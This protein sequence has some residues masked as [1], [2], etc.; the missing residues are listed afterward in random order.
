MNELFEREVSISAPIDVVFDYHRRPQALERLTPPWENLR[1][2]ERRGGIEDQG[3]VRLKLG[4]FLHWVARGLARPPKV[5]VCASGVGF[6]GDRGA[7]WLDEGSSGG[8]GLLAD[9]CRGWEAAAALSGVR[10]VCAR[11]GMVLSRRDGALSLIAA[12]FEWG[13]GGPLGTGRQYL[14]W[15]GIDDAVGALHRAL[16]DPTLA[17]AVNV[18]AP[19]PVENR[20]FAATLGRVLR[21]PSLVRIPAFAL[22]LLLGRQKADELALG[23]QRVRPGVL[24]A[25]GFRYL[26]PDLEPTLRH[27]YG[28]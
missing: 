5:F 22:R 7:E 28:R 26:T 6:Y 18:V 20:E 27:L 10:T 15:I 8:K 14:S 25:V 19:H 17:G 23:G 21:R 9:V 1:V 4:P 24:S 12:P 2:L 16:F 3:G 11:I 13:L